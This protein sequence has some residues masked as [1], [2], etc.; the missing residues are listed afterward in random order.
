[1][2]FDTELRSLISARRPLLLAL[3]EPYHGEPAFPGLR[4]RI[5]DTLA[6]EGFRSIAIESDRAAALAVDDYV[7][8][9]RDDVDL[10][11][12]ISHGWGAHPATRDL[13][14][15]LRAHNAG[16]PPSDRVAVHGFDAPTEIEAAPS[17]GPYLRKLR[18]YLGA[19]APGLDDLVGPDTRWTAPEI[20]Y[21]ATR[22]PGRSPEAAALRG[23]AED[24]RTRLYGHAPRLVK[25]TSARAWRHATVLASTVIG[26][27]TYHAAMA[28]PG[29]HSE[30]IAGLL[31]ARD[32]LMAQNLLDIL[33]AERDRGPVLVAAHNT[34]LQRG[35]SRWETHWEGV[36]YAAEWS[37]AGSI[38]SALLGDRYV[39]VAGSLGASGPA[40]L[41]A[42]EPGTYEER[43]GPDTGLFPP[44]AGAGLRER[45]HEL[46]GHFALTR[47]IVESS[48]AILHIG[49]GPGAAVAAR[50][51]ALPGVT[52]TRIE[53]GSDM[54]PYT[55]GD[56]F[57]F[58]GEDRMRPFATIVHHDV[59]GFDERSQ[60]S[61]EGRHRLNIEVGR[62]E[63]GNLFG[64]GPEEFATHQDKIDFTE[65]DRLIPHPAYAVQ[66]W[67]AIVDPGPAT[68][69]EATRL[70]A[71]ARSRSAA[72]EAR[73]S[74]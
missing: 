70:L 18:D 67:A 19:E 71:Q 48:D 27:L 9:L 40:G 57:F 32:A 4:N 54:P 46:L 14:D 23:L 6:G 55:W 43:L 47:E 35:P 16:R 5:L 59:P 22:S 52:E 61:A 10:S 66:G 2:A 45:E 38:V 39:F 21:D 17:P 73:R 62:T 49:H 30:R 33:A 26:L 60:L 12:G 74:R 69:T 63:F 34:H 15:G 3:G 7:Q 65:P 51:S 11:T 25:D 42:P 1:M 53:P 56:R 50:I 31:Q 68:A 24:F 8:G 58:A 44:P 36:D 37:G 13:I 72:R 29:T 20:M 41:G 64:Y 28:A